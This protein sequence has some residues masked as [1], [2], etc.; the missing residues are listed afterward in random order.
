MLRVLA[1]RVGARPAA[2]TRGVASGKE[3]V[4]PAA[5]IE[6]FR[7]KGY[8]LLPKFLTEA[9]LLPIETLYD[10]FMRGEIM[11][12]KVRSSSC[13]SFHARF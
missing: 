4:V 12:Q 5:A 1:R 6:S 10:A 9:E 2:H 8:A 13:A 11:S 7:T 3:Y